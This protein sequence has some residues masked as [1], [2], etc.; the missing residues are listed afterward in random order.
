MASDG[1]LAGAD[2]VEDILEVRLLHRSPHAA[3]NAVAE[4]GGSC[5]GRR[6]SGVPRFAGPQDR[7]VNACH[8]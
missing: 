2:S 4:E 5:R 6:E 1:S 8:A 7:R 3:A